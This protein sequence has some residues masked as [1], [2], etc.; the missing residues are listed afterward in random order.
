M[1]NIVLLGNLASTLF[2]TGLIWLIQLV[3]YPLFVQVGAHEFQAY[4]HRHST[5][6]TPLVGPAMLIE[7]LTAL[8]LAL[9]PAEDSFKTTYV[10]GAILLGLIWASTACIQVPLHHRLSQK[11]NARQLELLVDLNWIRTLLWSLRSTLLLWV[12]FSQ[13]GA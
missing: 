1:E 12:V 13:M 6:I 11:R 4:H 3:H 10:I 2:M 5:R 7:L 8:W 9:S